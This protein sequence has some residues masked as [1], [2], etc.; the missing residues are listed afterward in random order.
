MKNA[1][2]YLTAY[3][4]HYYA[5]RSTFKVSLERF[6][7]NNLIGFDFIK[8][9]DYLQIPED[10]SMRDFIA[11]NYGDDAMNM[12]FDLIVGVVE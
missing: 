11:D 5:F 1:L 7:I 10:I 6:W 3:K 9:D 4:K 2:P 12:V 8:F